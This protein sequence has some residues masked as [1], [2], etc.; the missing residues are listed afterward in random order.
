MPQFAQQGSGGSDLAEAGGA[1]PGSSRG[2]LVGPLVPVSPFVV[3]AATANVNLRTRL[4]YVTDI[5]SS[6]CWI[7]V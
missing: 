2:P 3:R 4:S 1:V 7:F 6:L 5:Q